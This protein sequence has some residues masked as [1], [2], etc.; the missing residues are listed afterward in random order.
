MALT[1]ERKAIR[2]NNTRKN[3]EAKERN[4]EIFLNNNA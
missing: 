4:N 1:V 2:N 3:N